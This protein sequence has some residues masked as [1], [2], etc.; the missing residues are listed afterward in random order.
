MYR[1]K[2]GREIQELWD[3]MRNIVNNNLIKDN[4]CQLI[5][6]F[7]QCSGDTIPEHHRY[8]MPNHSVSSWTTGG[9]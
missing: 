2:K 9:T 6:N 8:Y 3:L 4:R 7:C 1:E 5:V